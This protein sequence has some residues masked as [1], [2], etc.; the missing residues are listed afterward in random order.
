MNKPEV[1]T[2]S[3][4]DLYNNFK[5]VEQKVK[6]S[7]GASSG[8]QNLAF[9][10]APSTSSTNDANTASPQVSI[11]S[12]NVNTASTQVS[13]TSFSDNV[14]YAFMVE[15]PNGSNL[16]HQDLEQIH[17]DDLEAMDLKWQLSLLSMRAKS[18]EH[19]EARKSD[20]AEEQVQTNMALMAF[21]DSELNQTKFTA[22]TYKRGLAT[23]E[24]QLITYRKNEVLF[25]EEV[26]VL[27]RE[28]A[29]KDYE[30]NVLNIPPPHPL[31]YNRPKKLDLS[32]SGLDEFKE[33]E[34]KG[35]GLENNDSKENSNESLVEAQVSQDTSSFVEFSLNV[36][37][38]TIF[39]VDKKVE[40][41]KPKNHEKP[42]KRSVSGCSRHM[43]GN[44]AY[45]LDFKE[46]DGGY[47]AFGGGAY[48]GRI[49]GKGTL[50]TNSLDFKD[51]LLKIPRK[52]NM[53]SFDMKNIV[54]KEL[55][56][57]FVAKDSL[58]KFDG[59]SDEGF[60][61]GYSLSSKA[62]RVYNTRT[63]RVEENLHIR[64]LENKPMIEGN[65]PKWLF[66]IDSLTQ[67]MNYVPVTAG[68]ISNESAGTQGELNTDDPN[69]ENAEQDKFEDDSSTKEVNAARQHVNTA[70]PDVNTISY[71][72]EATHIEFFSDEDEPEVDLGN[73]TNS[74]TVPTTPNTRIH[75]DHPIDNV[76]GDVKSSVQ[77]RRM[78]KPTSEQGFLSDV[79]EQKTHDTLNTC[80]YVVSYNKLLV[81]VDLPSD[82]KK[83]LIYEDV[84]APVTRIEAKR[85]FFATAS[86]MGFSPVNTI[87]CNK[88]LLIWKLLR[89][90]YVTQ[91]PGFKILTIRQ[92]LPQVVKAHFLFV[93][94]APR[95]M[96]YRLG[97]CCIS[98]ASRPDYHCL[99]V[100]SKL[101][102]PTLYNTTEAEY[103]VA[104]SCC[105][106]VLWIQNQLLDY[107]YNFMH[108]VINIDNNS[109][110][111]I[112]ENPVQ[113]SKT[114]HIEIRHHFIRDCNAKKL[115]Q[116]VKIHTDHNV[117]DLLTKGFDAGRHVK[118]GRDTKIPQF[119]GLPVKVGD[120]AVHKEL[121]GRM[122]MAATTTSSLEAKHDSGSGLRCQDTILGDVDAQTRFETTSKQSNDPPL[123]RGYTL[124]SG[125]DSMKLLELI[126]L[127]TQL[128][129]GYLLLNAAKL[130]LGSVYA[131]RHMLMLLVQV[132]AAKESDGFAEII[133]FLKASSVHYALTVNPIIYTSCI[134]QFW[135]TTK[136]QTV[137]EVRQLQAL[138][139]K[140]KV[141]ITESSIRS[142]L[143]LDDAEVSEEVGEDSDHPTDSNQIPIVDQPS[144]YS[145]HKQKQK[146]KRKQRK[147]AEVP[148][149]ETK[150]EESVS[151][152]S[153][154]PQP[155]GEDSMQLNDLMVLC[156]KLQAQVLDLE[157]AKDAQ[158]KEIAALKKRVQKSI[159]DID[160]D[161]EVTLVD[162]TQE[163][164]DE[165]LMFDTG[166]L[167]SDEMPVEAK[168]DEKNEQS[169][170][171]DDSTAG[172]AVTT[173]G[174]EDSVA[175]TI[176]TTVEETLAQTLM[177]IKAA[178]P[179]AKGIV[180]HDQEEQQMAR[181][182]QAQLEAEIIEEEKLARK[183]EEEAN[184][185]LIESWDNTQAMMEADFE[186]A[187][188][189]QNREREKEI[190]IKK[191][192]TL[193]KENRES[194]KGTEDELEFDKLKKAEGSE[195]KTKG[196][197]KKMLRRKRASVGNCIAMVKSSLP[198]K[199]A[200]EILCQNLDLGEMMNQ[201]R[202]HPEVYSK[203]TFE[204]VS[205][206]DANQKFLRSLP[207]AW[208]QSFLFKKT[209]HRMEQVS[210][211]MICINNLRVFGN[212]VK[213]LY[214]IITLAPGKVEFV[215]EN[216]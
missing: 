122:E 211:L 127:Y 159:E 74:Y 167:D 57:V 197:R 128:L 143:H 61:V 100:R 59:K 10:T 75:R 44:I 181:D 20:M 90:V 5:I 153:N 54:L 58:G 137:N 11:A 191:I 204:G 208:S 154:D 37:K 103:V 36:D 189:L 202:C 47:V 169:T 215:S 94:H 210:A 136:V 116:M 173:A 170:K 141:I 56:L 198:L 118:R 134:E 178:K 46:F 147:E 112:I 69:I 123:S 60:F 51:I 172:E 53:Y 30:I 119:S 88:V 129:L 29:C 115:I 180:F 109:T 193:L 186:L 33:P 48:G 102:L 86:F 82:K 160:V 148:Q 161:V 101:W 73:I 138:V 43:T 34:F 2:M 158:A 41:A 162:E 42:V 67:S 93:I 190:T 156:T 110:I 199:D 83:V 7:I 106:Q 205:F 157:K 114:K 72:L 66:D 135:A 84:F 21:S 192:K 1:E 203:A 55:I 14:V 146:S 28:V 174:V 91:P 182:V 63:K 77:I 139:N 8:A 22:A 95:S 214:C 163:R 131:V 12:P 176:P 92:S 85:L 164:Q 133:D 24:E 70:S 213:G 121:G 113:H 64:F 98:R 201:R 175:P 96:I 168:I 35:Y 18:V 144:T 52:D 125:D 4:D 196:S 80:L 185:A 183:Q 107:G 165:D 184:I 177:E 151:T 25:S 62:F 40:L 216:N 16:L 89:R 99:H 97:L 149:D 171:L 108:T 212:D 104:A 26:A 117:A 17:E 207:S 31:I 152:P 68:T 130:M 45:L 49:T 206:E 78:T 13:T 65:G 9:M 76:I 155:S 132:L 32:Y 145:Q 200:E 23:V 209:K 126:E 3:I 79:Y 188:R 39:P 195:E 50:K 120:E 111:C 194:S 166:V 142:D 124:G 140:K 87:G 150:H 179:K 6:K 15:N 27:K 19:Q 105:G 38:E 187:Q 71:T 81:L